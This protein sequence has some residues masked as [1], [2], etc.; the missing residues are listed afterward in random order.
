MKLP[1]L[2]IFFVGFQGISGPL[3]SVYGNSE[4]SNELGL[5]GGS[6]RHE[7]ATFNTPTEE[8][9]CYVED[10]VYIQEGTVGHSHDLSCHRPRD[11]TVSWM[12][13][14][15]F[16]PGFSGYF[17]SL[18][19]ADAGHYTCT[20]SFRNA[21]QVYKK[22]R[23]IKLTVLNAPFM[24]EPKIIEPTNNAKISVTV[25]KPAAIPCKAVLH[26]RPDF[27]DIFWITEK[28]FVSTNSNAQV[29]YSQMTEE[30]EDGKYHMIANLS[31][32]R[33]SPE[34]LNETYTCKFQ[35]PSVGENVTITL[36]ARDGASPSLVRLWVVGLLG[37]TALVLTI[38]YLKF[39]ID[40]VL[41]FRKLRG[42]SVSYSDGKQYDAYVMHYEG[43][44]ADALTEEERKLIWRTLET[45]F[46]YQLCL[47][48]RDVLPGTAV[49]EAVLDHIGRSHRLL[50]LPGGPEAGLGSWAADGSGGVPGEEQ[51]LLSALHAALVE[52]QTRLILV[53]RAAQ[54]EQPA[55]SEP[56]RLL[57]RSGDTV[58]W[59]GNCSRP[60]SSRFWKKLRYHMPAK[61]RPYPGVVGTAML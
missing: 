47:F 32:K 35:S 22:S 61:R 38:V 26:A 31:F 17:K 50:L 42:A 1:S 56:L 14:C 51:A 2:V 49:L 20:W 15:K 45:E 19:T 3:S 37:G 58:V 54:G 4:K 21:T 8:G 33:V 9:K 39:R 59:R 40:I 36:K 6:N 25:G 10:E 34:H 5:T 30:R 24:L 7:Q 43:S 23:T 53:E 18:G 16:E 13:D 11:S 48:Q 27:D 41:L 60:S 44:S 57:A 46:G 12:K 29:H 28:S 52:R 55:L